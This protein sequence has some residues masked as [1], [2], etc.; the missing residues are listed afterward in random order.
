MKLG[1]FHVSYFVCA[2]LQLQDSFD[3][4]DDWLKEVNRHASEGTMKLL[5]GNKADMVD[6]K[7]VSQS[8]AQVCRDQIPPP[9]K[10]R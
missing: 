6:Q 3:H 1:D 10:Y 7:K 9:P 2:C 4:V 5:V 8:D